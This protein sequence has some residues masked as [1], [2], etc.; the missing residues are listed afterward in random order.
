MWA[1]NPRNVLKEVRPEKSLGIT[2]IFV[3]ASPRY[4][5]SCS[6]PMLLGSLDNL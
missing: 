6:I 1:G 4:L 3:A 5:K 2:L